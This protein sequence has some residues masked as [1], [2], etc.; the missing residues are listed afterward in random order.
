MKKILHYSSAGYL[1]LLMLIKMMG[2]QIAV[3][4][5]SLHKDFIAA[6]LCENRAKPEL[7]CAGKCYLKKQLSRS[8]ESSDS[9]EAKG[10]SKNFSV[11][12]FEQAEMPQFDNR[13]AVTGSAMHFHI[14][15]L[16][17]PYITGIFHPPLPAVV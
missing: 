10:N 3:L 16:N 4:D 8:N 2:M 17:N 9:Q 1:L 11:D 12:F 7:M 5:Y 6:S 14:D 13:C 15:R